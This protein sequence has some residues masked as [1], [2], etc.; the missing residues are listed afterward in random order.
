MNPKRLLPFICIFVSFISFA[1]QGV[2]GVVL[3]SK[4]KPVGFVTIYCKEPKKAT[5]SNEDGSYE[6]TL[7]PGEHQVY[8]Q[9]VGYKTTM[10]T[11]S[12]GSEYIVSNPVL[13]EQAYNLKEVSVSSGRTNPA[14]WIM[15]KAIAAAPYYKRQV[16]MYNSKVYIKG[17]GKLDKIPFLFEKSLKKDGIIEGKTFLQESINEVTFTQP[18]TYKEKALSVK[19]SMPME[20]MPQPM[21]MARG[22]MYHT[23][24]DGPVSPLS[25]QAFSVYD[26]KLEGSFYEDGKEVNKIKITPK[27]KGRDVYSGYMYIMEGLWCIHSSDLTS[28]SSNFKV[29]IITSFRP[30]AGYDYVWMPV[31]YDINVSGG[32]FGFEGGFR[33][34]ASVSNYKIKLNPNLDHKWV[35]QHTKDPGSLAIVKEETVQPKPAKPK[36]KRQQDIDALLAKE[37]L[38]KLEMLKLANKM[39]LESEAEQRNNLRVDEDSS[40]MEI[41]SLAGKRDSSFWK[42]NRMVPLMES[43]VVSYKQLDSLILKKDSSVKDTS[44]KHKGGFDVAGIFFGKRVVFN[45]KKNYF[46]WSGIGPGGEI[47][48]NTVDGWGAAVQWQLGNIR[49]DVKEWQF[50]HKIRVPFERQC[51]NTFARLD[52]KYAPLTKGQLS[53]EGGTFV[54]DFNAKGGPSPFVSNIMLIVDS[55]NFLKLYQQEYVKVNHEKELTN[56]L[57]WKTEAGWYHR[58]EL[59]NISRYVKK[60]VDGKITPNEPVPGYHMPTHDASIIVNSITYTPRQRYRLDSGRKI[61]VQGSLPTFLVTMT[62]GIPSVLN[63]TVDF[64]KLSLTVIERI[65][66]RHWLTVNAKVTHGF[67][68]YNNRTYFPDYNQFNGNRAPVLTGD[69][70]YVFRQLDYYNAA[71]TNG[72]TTLHAEFDFKR[73]LFK[74]LPIINMTG[75]REVIFYN[76]LHVQSQTPYQEIGYGLEALSGIVR[77]DVFAGYKGSS[78]NNWGVRVILNLK[79]LG[80]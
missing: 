45:Q 17:S 22:S 32:F 63:S 80:L 41:D 37:Q 51:V 5:N 34:L 33:Y 49:K 28:S 61:Y 48:L 21:E 26:F 30:V 15:R 39:K 70:L 50:T 47:F 1:Q 18:N 9:S 77:A 79:G 62:N 75:I 3:D 42:E 16:L 68:L 66:L 11:V 69:P 36:T 19:S 12:V 44:H 24:G 10:I 67:F 29:H 2:K 56:G 74:R 35:Q 8:F 27:R 38:S 40:T 4:N 58:Y 46:D 43:E 14:V 53:F 78:Y 73:L 71:T 6:L 59:D 23:G 60:E 52:Y 64:G 72:Y 55:R 57:L 31:T 76:G 54:S 25:P 7:P 65:K 13:A 20:G